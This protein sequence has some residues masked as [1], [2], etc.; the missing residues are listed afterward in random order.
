MP[1]REHGVDTDLLPA[2]W[3]TEGIDEVSCAAEDGGWRLT[4][5]ADPGSRYFGLRVA[6]PAEA[7]AFAVA[8]L[9]LAYAVPQHD[10]VVS[11]FLVL[12]EWREG[13]QLSFQTQR[14]F[15]LDP[16]L[17]DAELVLSIREPGMRVEALLL[18]ERDP[19]IDPAQVTLALRA[20]VLTVA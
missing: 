14:V 15:P 4:L 13:G 11:L 9:R 8:T 7:P 17:R 10:G 20:P 16:A 6:P 2:D 19:S 1:D 18:I 3:V 12:R 5:A